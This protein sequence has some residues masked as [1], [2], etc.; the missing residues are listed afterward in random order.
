MQS[1]LHKSTPKKNPVMDVRAQNN[2][3]NA[4]PN[5]VIPK[6][7]FGKPVKRYTRFYKRSPTKMGKL[8]LHNTSIFNSTAKSVLCFRKIFFRS[9]FYFHNFYSNTS[10]FLLGRLVHKTSYTGNE[11]E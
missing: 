10:F 2:F 11:A 5:N 4:P 3:I 9:M 7:K 8:Q 1:P 6:L